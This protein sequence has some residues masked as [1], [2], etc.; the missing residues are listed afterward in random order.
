MD[1]CSRLVGEVLEAEERA[2]V[3]V[4]HTLCARPRLLLPARAPVHL[5]CRPLPCALQ[6]RGSLLT[7]SVSHSVTHTLS[8][9]YSVSHTFC[10]SQCHTFCL[11]HS[12]CHTHSVSHTLCVTYSVSHMFCISQCHTHYVYHTLCVSHTLCLTHSVC[13]THS[14]QVDVERQARRLGRRPSRRRGVVSPARR[15]HA[16]F[17]AASEIQISARAGIQGVERA[18]STLWSVPTLWLEILVFYFSREYGAGSSCDHPPS[19][20]LLRHLLRA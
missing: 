17:S 6:Q 8:H 3:A 12:V 18:V 7:H 13:H 14:V 11:T 10:D 1:R 19:P 5:L 2:G 15:A 4:C 16:A 9:T 20:A